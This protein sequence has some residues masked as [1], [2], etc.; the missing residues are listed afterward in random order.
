MDEHDRGASQAVGTNP[1]RVDAL[2][3]VRGTARYIADIRLDGTLI[4]RALRS[5]YP[6]AQIVRI[7]TAAARRLP[8]VHAVLTG[9]DTSARWGPQHKDQAI[10]AAEKVRYVGDE[11][12]A[13]AAVDRQTAEEA[14]GLIEVEY[15]EL[16]GVFD[17]VE[18]M[19][20]GAPLVHD[21]KPGNVVRHFDLV[22]GDPDA[23]MAGAD[24]VIEETFESQR[25]WHASLEPTGSIARFED[26]RL[27]L[28]MNT[29]EP[30][31]AR[32]AA[33]QALGI[34]FSKVRVIQSEVGGSFGGRGHDNNAMICALLATRCDRP[35][36]MVNTR[37]EDFTATV[38]RMPMRVRI[39]LGL[40]RDGT[41]V[42]KEI[43][44]IADNGAYTNL[45]PEVAAVATLRHDML[46][47]YADIRSELF[48]VH[49]NTIPTGAFRGFGNPS[50][51]WAMQQMIDMA[52]RAL[53]MDP[54]ELL[55]RN[56]NDGEYTSQHGARVLSSELKA[57]VRQASELIGWQ[58]KRARRTPNRG[59]GFSV[60]VMVSG[61]R[62]FRNF[63]GSSA[64]VNV[65]I[66]GRATLWCGEGETGPG[67]R[68]VMGQIVAEELGIPFTDV[69]VSTADTQTSPHAFGTFASR[70]T[71]IAG[72]AVRD[73]ARRAREQVLETASEL[74]EVA[75]D[76][77][78][79]RDGVISGKGAP[80]GRTITVA[81]AVSKR[82]FGRDGRPI[83]VL[84][85]WD[86]PS[87]MQ[88]ETYYGNELGAYNYIACAVEVEV[89][90]ETGAF[91]ILDAAMACDAGRIIFPI[92][93]QGQNEGAL[94]Q[95]LGY[96]VTESLM[97]E[98]GRL[99][100]PN[101]SDYR[102]PS[103]ADMPPFQHTFVESYEPT[104][105]FGAKGLGQVGLDPVAPAIANAIADATGVRIT[106][107][108]IVPEKVLAGLRAA[109][110][111]EGQA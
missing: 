69:T 83:S 79:I 16:P 15:A 30:F 38:P 71:Y 13:V 109:S 65:E 21:D 63:D 39:R 57:C 110:R 61:K 33:S 95:G 92:G 40:R 4:G 50:G 108:P 82:L 105:P 36:R 94:A 22:R 106:T 56:V 72:N 60:S 97:M 66:D 75:A 86:P 81:E 62:H 88:D 19:Q 3:K 5:P 52:A 2:D 47:R 98:D 45:G 35:V 17:P 78:E 99:Q 18:A 10:L 107:L 28:W 29:N 84:G 32:N 12:A 103:I 96:A 77:L 89:D 11:V 41:I 53:D 42:A 23:A 27:T 73:A 87:D 102:I 54:V 1:R 44:T 20:P 90:P 25:Q 93:A 70:A 37:E 24:V 26:G 59:L 9:A 43:R 85:H 31:A 8:G 100:N 76:D 68:T 46:F 14:L 111:P 48:V 104:G 67:T 7:D 58:E 55:M 34:P 74:L 51:Q 101:F 80:S 49:T 91:T 64:V 6:H